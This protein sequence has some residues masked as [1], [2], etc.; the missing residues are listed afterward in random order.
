MKGSRGYE[1]IIEWLNSKGYKPFLYQEQAW[2]L[3]AERKSGLVNAPTGTG[4]TFSIFL[5]AVINY[6]NQYPKDY[7]KERKNGLQLIWV[8][9]L[10]ALAKDIGRAM[11][12]VLAELEIPWKVGIRNGDTSISERQK[13]KRNLKS[14]TGC[15]NKF[16]TAWI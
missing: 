13:Q 6:I 11:E 7:K 16:G 2:Q 3:I 12:E 5:G 15:P 10:R 4:K 14:V 9:P 8:T 1:L